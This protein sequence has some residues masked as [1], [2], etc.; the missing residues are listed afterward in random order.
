MFS[1][2]IL[3]TAHQFFPDYFAGTEVLTF[4]VA[5]ELIRRGHQV[6]VF[7]GYPARPPLPY[8]WQRFDH[9]VFEGIEVYRFFHSFTRTEDQRAI[10][11]LEY[12]NHQAAGFFDHLLE[13]VHPDI[14]HFFHLSRLG[15]S[16]VDVAR[17][18]SIPAYFTPTDFWAICPTSQ[19]L[20]G[21]GDLCSGPSAGGGKCIKHVATAAKWRREVELLIKFLPNRVV[22][23]I[24][25]VTRLPIKSPIPLR[26]EIAALS[27]R[28]SFNVNR[29]NALSAIFSPTQLMTDVLTRNGVDARLIVQSAYGLNISGFDEVRR[30]YDPAKPLTFGFIGTLAPHKGCHVLIEAF[31]R[32]NRKGVR[33]HIYGDLEHFSEY[34]AKLKALAG[35]CEDIAFLGT[36]PNAEIAGVFAGI[37]ALVVPSLWYENAPLVVYSGLAAKCPVIASNFPGMSEVVLNEH[38]GL[39]FEPGNIEALAQCLLRLSTT[40]SLLKQL[41]E[42]CQ[43][44]KSIAAYV[45]ELIGMYTQTDRQPL[46]QLPPR[47]PIPSYQPEGPY[48]FIV[49]WAAI[50]STEPR[51]VGLISEG[52]EIARTTYLQPRLDARTRVKYSGRFV[53][54]NK[55]GFVMPFSEP[56]TSATA[57]LVLED[58][59]G[60]FHQ[61]P[62]TRLTVGKPVEID[63]ELL[64][65]IDEV[66]FASVAA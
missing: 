17:Q 39:T 47:T 35:D 30:E 9:Y 2:K 40:P 5:K 13:T 45:D 64:V 11:E 7:T 66:E 63:S 48:G 19:L 58:R 37:D 23:W 44:P 60:Y 31:R 25:A 59:H 16:L 51:S 26:Q 54:G 32:L 10:L 18:K 57:V 36:F 28:A 20:L 4:S 22:D 52:H 41:S 1:M 42:Q 56:V 14:V 49:G 50:A 3:L 53:R 27:R 8:P 55:Y 38:N 65:C 61:I 12:D 29:L 33:L 46:H 15:T 6:F 62:F 43:K 21:N 34:V 24:A